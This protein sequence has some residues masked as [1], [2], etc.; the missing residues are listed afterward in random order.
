L[1][2]IWDE[3]KPMR[4]NEVVFLFFVCGAISLWFLAIAYPVQ[5]LLIG[6]VLFAI[7]SWWIWRNDKNGYV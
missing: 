3:E 6:L 2:G 4:T 7:I 1:Y 5:A